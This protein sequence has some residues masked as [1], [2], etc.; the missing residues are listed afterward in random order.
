MKSYS[1]PV[2]AA[3]ASGQIGIVQFLYLGFPTPI[4]LNSSNR[5]FDWLG[6]TYKG[7]YGLG[8]ISPTDDKPGEVQGLTLSIAGGSSSQISLAL[9]D[10]DLVQGSSVIVRTAVVDLTTLAVLDAPVEWT[11]FCD[12]MGIAEDGET[13]SISVSVESGAVA[14]LRGNPSTYSD[15]DQRAKYPGDRSFEYVISQADKPVVWPSRE[16]FFK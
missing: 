6:V 7:A 10:A 11:G 5:D 14:L 15:A 12:K 4:A 3:L 2:L 13:A 9:D 1:A 8:E 16:W